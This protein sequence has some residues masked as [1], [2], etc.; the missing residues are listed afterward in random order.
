LTIIE[1]QIF[2]KP[3]IS[4]SACQLGKYKDT[5]GSEVCTSCA[6]NTYSAQS[7]ATS[8]ET[9][10]DCPGNSTSVVASMSKDFCQ[11]NVGFR[12]DDEGCTQC[13]PGTYN[14]RLAQ[15][16]CSNCTIGT[17]SLNFGATNNETCAS[18]SSTEYSPEGSPVCLTCP[19]NS[20]SPPRSGRIQDCGCVVGYTGAYPSL[21]VKCAPGKYKNI[22]GNW[23][24]QSCSANSYSLSGATSLTQCFCNDGF[25]GAYGPL[26]VG[27]A[28]GKYKSGSGS[29]SNSSGCTDCPA[30]T[31]ADQE[32]RTV[33]TACVPTSAS[34]VGSTS[35]WNCTCNAGYKGPTYEEVTGHDNFAR[36]CGP[37]RISACTV[38]QSSSLTYAIMPG[39]YDFLNPAIF[40]NDNNSATMSM[41]TYGTNQWWRVDF[42][43]R[44]TVRTVRALFGSFGTDMLYVH[45]GDVA[46]STG[47]LIC[48]TVS[49]QS[50]NSTW[51]TMECGTPLTGQF[52]YV[53]N[54]VASEVVIREIQAQGTEVLT[55]VWPD[56]CEKCPTGTYKAL[57]GN[58]PCTACPS[59][60][61]SAT[62]AATSSS[63]CLACPDYSV[64][65]TGSE[66]CGCIPGFSGSADACSA[67]AID[68][69]K[70]TIGDSEC[71]TCPVNSVISENAHSL[72]LPCSCLSG[73]EPR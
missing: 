48:T 21:C 34:V 17:Y 4:C 62:L 30:N 57:T 40:A 14:P 33:C 70:N 15:L 3:S 37:L 47:N 25:Q 71:A 68:T 9:C 42:G 53:R 45:V 60:T 12:H 58:L 26:C 69:Y 63:V 44:V 6:A 24:C 22:T 66:Q 11:C 39:V 23:L 28:I 55:K 65:G 16:A 29:G 38:T 43:R 8:I 59:N 67:C 5:I 2:G 73:F 20:E 46:T 49:T 7:N 72:E 36:S 50:A 56:F 19:P 51:V 31:Y 61:F 64:S 27:C 54:S 52:L 13:L 41:T 35:V 10:L 18:C 32:G 1:W